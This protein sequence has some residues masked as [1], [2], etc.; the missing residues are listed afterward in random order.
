MAILPAA[1]AGKFLRWK[2]DGTLENVTISQLLD[3][4]AARSSA[5][6]TQSRWLDIS[7]IP[8]TGAVLTAVSGTGSI[9]DLAVTTPVSVTV[10]L[11]AAQGTGSIGDITASAG[12]AAQTSLTA[13]QGTGS[14][15]DLEVTTPAGGDIAFVAAGAQTRTLSSMGSETIDM[16]TVAQNDLL[17]LV[18]EAGLLAASGWTTKAGSLGT[19]CLLYKRAGASEADFSVTT[20]DGGGEGA[21]FSA[22]VFAFRG[23][24]G[25]GD[26]FDATAA[27]FTSTPSSTT[28]TGSALNIAAKSMVCMA[29]IGNRATS[30]SGGTDTLEIQTYADTP[31]GI[32]LA[33][34]AT[35]PAGA[36]SPHAAPVV[37]STAPNISAGILTF[38]LKAA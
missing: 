1:Q 12:Q 27:G 24:I 11:A 32:S 23:V 2:A 26:P 35:P 29:F 17:L 18:S 8:D 37:T 13:A 16:P 31:A 4:I 38:A 36:E 19:R 9:G 28:H 15:G 21:A 30:T 7:A 33:Y 10:E 22:R 34:D 3:S 6:A 5:E 20:D 14:I 25:S